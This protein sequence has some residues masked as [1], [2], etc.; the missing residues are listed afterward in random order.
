MFLDR[1]G[2][3]VRDPG[4]VH[5]VEDY[6]LLPEVAPALRRLAAAGFRL[7]IVTNQSG[8]GRGYYRES[9]FQAFQ[10][11]LLRDL[12]AGGIE[13]AA[14]FHCPHAPEAGCPC[15]KPAPGL[16][17]QARDELDA[18][19]RASWLIGDGEPDVGAARAAG[20]RGV[21]RLTPRGRAAR[22]EPAHAPATTTQV[23]SAP[24][25]A[26]A[27]GLILLQEQEGG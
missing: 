1:D 21:V 10:A 20:L 5:R 6:A 12:A 7:A 24:T 2:T 26:E 22:G 11:H 8:I 13:I 25:L 27:A 4:Y 23:L 3:L 17:W 19:L 18:D 16:L 9:D 14:S 15:R